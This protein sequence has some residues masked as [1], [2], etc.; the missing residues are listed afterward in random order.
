MG[1]KRFFSDRYNLALIGFIV[2]FFLFMNLNNHQEMLFDEAVRA[3]QGAFFHDLFKTWLSGDLMSLSN[4][5]DAYA[6]RYSI[7]WGVLYPPPAH[8][9]LQGIL[10]LF[11]GVKAWYAKL[12]T[13]LFMV[14]GIV[15]I[16]LI[17]KNVFKSKMMGL[18]SAMFISLSPFIFEFSRIG[19]HEAAIMSMTA[20]WFYFFFY[21]QGKK[22]IIK[23][24]RI[25]LPLRTSVIWAGLCMTVA[26]LMKYPTI[27]YMICFGVIYSIFL[28]I[29][30]KKEV[31]V[32]NYEDIFKILKQ[33]G[34]YTLILEFI[35]IGIIFLM[36]GG[37]WLKFSLFDH[38]MFGRV[39]LEGME[40][41]VWQQLGWK[42]PVNALTKPF[43]ALLE[44]MAVNSWVWLLCLVPFI[45]RI[46]WKKDG[47]LKENANLW[48]FILG[49]YVF[50]TFGMSHHEIRYAIQF[51]PMIG[52]L[53]VKGMQ[54]IAGI[55]YKKKE[56]IITLL[57]IALSIG[58]FAYKDYGTTKYYLDT[59]GAE[60]N[61]VPN[62]ILSKPDPKI[63]INVKGYGART[64]NYYYSPE[65]YVFKFMAQKGVSDPN[66]IMHSYQYIYW[67]QL[68]QDDQYKAF[69]QQIAQQ[70][71]QV[72]VYIF[73]FEGEP[74][75]KVGKL[76]SELVNDGFKE[77]SVKYFKIYEKLPVQG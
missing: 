20:G 48:M 19:M 23:L 69:S 26:T 41:E 61:A 21:H 10:F 27:I 47:F 56:M 49:V 25:K 68:E 62:Y 77:T 75:N 11:F 45:Y 64:V 54:D 13:E 44:I 38:G 5:F 33:S 28:V 36:L 17:S 22:F 42:Y 1:K 29:K 53:A 2:L 12:A 74:D 15:M 34:V 65:L 67:D 7:G 76:G 59:Y 35:I 14:F 73:M 24:G 66:K 4:F 60:E 50:Y 9:I 3:T 43:A 58:F 8:G 39:M 31:K 37:W 63:I 18:A 57:I 51:F 6:E 40:R 55:I 30:K 32:E 72:P 16:Y 46:F 70:A 71:G 52:I